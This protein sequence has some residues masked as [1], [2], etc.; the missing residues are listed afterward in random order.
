MRSAPGS[1]TLRL[2]DEAVA[3]GGTVPIFGKPASRFR[4][5]VRVHSYLQCAAC[6]PEISTYLQRTR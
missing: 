5:I 3:A 6:S 1:G 4:N 2:E